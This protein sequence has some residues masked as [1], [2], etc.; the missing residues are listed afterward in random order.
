MTFIGDWMNALTDMQFSPGAIKLK[1]KPWI[2]NKITKMIK[3]RNILFARKKKAT[4]QF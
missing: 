3:F 2:T 1:S 4:Q